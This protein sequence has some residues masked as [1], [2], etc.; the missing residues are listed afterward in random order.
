MQMKITVTAEL[1]IPVVTQVEAETEAEAL[2]IAKKRIIG[3][4]LARDW[5]LHE[6]WF[7]IYEVKGGPN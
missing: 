4:D 5:C 7:D 1:L 3:R 6:D 2:A